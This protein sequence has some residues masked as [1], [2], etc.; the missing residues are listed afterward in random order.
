M[1]ECCPK[2]LIVK[3]LSMD[4]LQDH[5]MLKDAWNGADG[6]PEW[7]D[8]GS[9]Y[10]PHDWKFGQVVETNAVSYSMVQTLQ[11]DLRNPVSSSTSKR[12][13]PVYDK[14][15]RNKMQVEIHLQITPECA[16]PEKCQIYGIGQEQFSGKTMIFKSGWIV[17]EPTDDRTLTLTAD[18]FLPLRVSLLDLDID[19][20][21]KSHP[22][23]SQQSF[24]EMF[25]M[26]S[27]KNKRYVTFGKPI[28]FA[29]RESGV[30]LRRMDRSV[31]W[32]GNASTN[33]H[34][35]VIKYLFGRYSA[36]T[37]VTLAPNGTSYSL[38][39]SNLSRDQ[40]QKLQDNPALLKRLGD[41]DWSGFF[42]SDVGAWPAADAEL[43]QFG[44]ECQA[45]C[46]LVIG[47]MRQL[48]SPAELS[49][50]YATADFAHPDT[51]IVDG[52]TGNRPT[53]PDPSKGYT[54]VDQEV[55]KG[56]KY[57]R[58]VLDPADGAMK[59]PP[60]NYRN[61]DDVG[62][63]NFEAYLRYEY[64][65]NGSDKSR[66]YGGGVGEHEGNPI[67]VFW[68]IAE[69]ESGTEEIWGQTVEYRLITRVHEYQGD[70]DEEGE[71][72]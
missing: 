13:T 62:W 26:E 48:G 23:S 46:R 5:H 42:H 38:G 7:R 3:F 69:Y 67:H 60:G 61:S 4:Y 71:E 17:L 20:Y 19:W 33:D 9:L 36:Y 63:N 2:K 58:Q 28:L 1:A 66:W 29:D 70:D 53:G 49:L 68:G 14:A 41:F 22:S 16:C 39:Y 6:K 12:G 64:T 27:S 51:A 43:V 35:Y 11:P 59:I 56:K 52:R 15:N 18:S 47:I 31:E 21:I 32:V 45:I 55:K 54:L 65:E 40:K 44:A 34:A 72:E 10:S 25:N 37:L 24:P 30:T 57:I 8:T 50:V